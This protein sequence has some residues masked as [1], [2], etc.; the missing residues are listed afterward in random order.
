MRVSYDGIDERHARAIA[1]VV[2]AARAIA[3]VKYGFEI[4]ETIYVDVSTKA[5]RPVRLFN[6]GVD[7]FSLSLRSQAD[8]RKPAVSGAY[9]LYGLCHEVGHLAMY[10]PIKDHAWLST[11]GAE[12]WAH[13]LGSV[14]VDEVHAR[15]GIEL[16]PDAYDYRADGTRRLDEQLARPNASDVVVGARLW[17]ELATAV[18]PEKLPALFA[19]WG[20]VK[21]NPADPVAALRSE[22]TKLIPDANL[23]DWW[24]DAAPILFVSREASRFPKN[25]IDAHELTGSPRALLHDDGETAGKSSIAGGGHAVRFH[26]PDGSWFL[27]SVEIFGSR[28]GAA[29]PPKEDFHV[30]LCD[31]QMRAVAD[32]EFP[33]AKF[34]RGEPAWVKLPVDPTNVPAEFIV[35]VGFNPAATKGVYVHYDAKGSGNSLTGLPGAKPRVFARGDWMIRVEVD[36]SKDADALSG[37]PIRR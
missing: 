22:L 2:E 32:F 24:K 5:D 6:D 12:G 13:Y 11:A 35:C 19:A 8:L 27:T 3:A 36:Q 33:Y 17:R 10:R 20:R 18:G 29:V 15:D 30:W 34:D 28:Y 4:P 7:R 1:R 37:M 21:I 14:L 26:V 25:Q 23:A 16:W 31:E 9:H